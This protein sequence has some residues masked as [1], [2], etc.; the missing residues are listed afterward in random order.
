MKIEK[1]SIGIGDRFGREG[2][3]QLRALQKATGG[4][5][6]PVPVW[7]KSHR[8]HSLIGTRP[9]DVRAEADEAVRATG[10]KGAYYVDA[11][12]VGMKTVDAFLASSNFFTLDVADFIGISASD[13]AVASFAQEM[14]PFLG[15]LRIPGID[16]A[17]DVTPS[18]LEKIGRQYLNAVTEAGRTYRHIAASKGDDTFVVEVS[19]DEAPD[20]QLPFELFFIL[21]AIAREGVPIQTIAPKFS[22]KFLK[23]IDYVGDVSTFARE[24]Q[25]DL[26]VIE[27]AKRVFGLPSSLKVSVHTGS[28]KFSLYPAM[29]TA[30]ERNDVGLHLKTA[31][32]TWLEE[33][34]G[35]ALSGGTGLRIAKHIYAKAHAR[36]DELCKPYATVVEIDRAKLPSPVE[37]DAWTAEQFVRRLRHDPTCPDFSV[38]VRQLLHVAFKVAAEMG[39][40]FREALDAAHETA[41]R[42]VTE[43]LYERHIKPLFVG[44]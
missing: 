26:L 24:F 23:G 34:I 21:G 4:R 19:T 28:D 1:Y 35:V 30:I 36:F 16:A 39:P 27:H 9:E 17:F 42:C 13:A 33:V 44:G 5:A 37:V 32:T 8:E 2:V 25:A 18:V 3:A 11:D 15:A 29:R 14:T 7:N 38:H 43:N 20:P 10:W 31:G 22:G 12:H 6:A 41:G 40:E